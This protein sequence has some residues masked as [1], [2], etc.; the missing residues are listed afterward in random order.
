M[1]QNNYALFARLL[2]WCQDEEVPLIYA[3]SASVYGAG[4]EFREERELRAPLNVYGYSKFLF[5]QYV[6]RSWPRAHRAGR[7]ACATSTSTAPNEAHKGRMASVAFHF[8]QPATRA[9]AG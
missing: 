2:D 6:R 1:M 3:S 5:D 4:P 9:R 7:R 8:Y